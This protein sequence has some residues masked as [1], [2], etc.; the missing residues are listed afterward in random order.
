[1]DRTLT[2]TLTAEQ[3]LQDI[4]QSA[5][6]LRWFEQKFGLL[7]ETFYHLFQQGKLQDEDPDEITEC[8]EWA[9]QWEIYEDRRRRY[10]EAIERRLQQLPTPSSL[11]DL[12]VSQLPVAV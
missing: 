9:A 8:L 6:S 10:N 2:A 3:L 7:S 5:A 1:M 11:R 12:Q 4:Y